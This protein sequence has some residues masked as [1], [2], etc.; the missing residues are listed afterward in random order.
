VTADGKWL[1]DGEPGE[2]ISIHDRGFTYADGLFET[3]AIR[4]GVPRFFDYHLE[5]LAEGC[6]R[7]GIPWPASVADE[8]R[9]LA[10][11]CRFGTAKIIVTRGPGE[12]GYA[13]A[14]NPRATR[15]TGVMDAKPPTREC[16]QR[17][18]AVRFC[19]T[20]IGAHPS[21]AGM[22]TLDRLEQVMARSE[23]QDVRIR[24]GLMCSESG[25]VICGTM[26]NLFFVVDGKL[27]TPDLSRCGVRGV[28]RR[29]VMEGARRC[30]LVCSERQVDADDLYRAQ[31]IF[32]TNSLIG[33]W[34]VRQLADTRFEIGP[35]TRRLMGVLVEAGVTECAV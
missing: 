5:R 15:V 35:I 9:D 11:G 33:I 28:M 6:R 32:L 22:K 20:A 25:K 27:C 19:D 16:Y 26:T 1:V 4:N 30:K 34:P 14:E 17:G 21:L 10:A 24:E 2:T 12:R 8:V 3:V 29:A 13:P 7:L 18:V 31:E 23:W